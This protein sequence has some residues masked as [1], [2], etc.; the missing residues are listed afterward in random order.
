[1]TLDQERD[2]LLDH[3]R[4]PRNVGE[5]SDAKMG[6]CKNLACGDVVKVFFKE[7]DIKIKVSGCT[8]CIASASLMSELVKGQSQIK[9]QE[10]IFLMR[11][12]MKPGKAEW[13]SE[14]HALR[15]L[16]RMRESPMKIPCTLLSWVALERAIL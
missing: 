6:E 3:V 5:L 2:Y 12:S 14:L 16:K 13:P 11:E 1:M 7:G 9:I 10:Y 15:P 8:I 4:N